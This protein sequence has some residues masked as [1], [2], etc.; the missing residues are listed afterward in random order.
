M[1]RYR[2]QQMVVVKYPPPPKKIL[3]WHEDTDLEPRSFLTF[4]SYLIL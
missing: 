4:F 1:V 2:Y 3:Y